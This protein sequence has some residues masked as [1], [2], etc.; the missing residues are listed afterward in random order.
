MEGVILWGSITGALI[1]PSIS[2]DRPF[3][4][5]MAGPVLAQDESMGNALLAPTKAS[6]RGTAL[7]MQSFI[8]APTRPGLVLQASTDR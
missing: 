2:T 6:P 4:V 7:H 3:S 8:V 1:V 5:R